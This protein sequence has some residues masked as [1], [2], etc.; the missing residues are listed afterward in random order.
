MANYVYKKNK[1]YFRW[2]LIL[3]KNKQNYKSLDSLQII[4]IQFKV[5]INIIMEN[6]LIIKWLL[7]AASLFFF[8]KNM[9]NN[10]IIVKFVL[11]WFLGNYQKLS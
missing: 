5:I 6:D 3:L 11:G 4:S 10:N 7:K 1:L 8:I 2:V 9:D